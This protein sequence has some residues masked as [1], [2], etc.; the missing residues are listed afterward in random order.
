MPHADVHSWPDEERGG[1]TE[2][3]NGPYPSN[4]DDDDNVYLLE[5]RSRLNHL[6]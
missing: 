6:Q 5:N 1:G 3:E 2:L 4:D